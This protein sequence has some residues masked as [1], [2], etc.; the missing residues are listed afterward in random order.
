MEV[1]NDTEFE[2]LASLVKNK[3]GINLKSEK[4]Y[5][6][7]GRLQSVLNEKKIDSYGEYYQY[8]LHDPSGQGLKELVNRITTNHT[9]FMREPEHFEF[10]DRTVLPDIISSAGKSG[11]KDM[12]IWSAGCSSGEEPYCLAM[13]IQEHG[14][15]KP[16]EWD[17]KI[18][19]TDISPR[20]L[21]LAQ[22]G[23]YGPEQVSALPAL[24]KKKYFRELSAERY[25]VCPGI[26][27]EIIFRRF[28]LMNANFPFKKNFHVIFCRNVMIYFDAPTKHALVSK[29]EQVTEHGGFLF[30]GQSESL[31]KKMGS[32]RY[33]MP[34][35]YR[36][37]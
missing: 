19:A 35:V 31:G 36:R 18:L 21:E 37:D 5:L 13:I 8:L 1:L 15:F 17:S 4:K 3:Y 30:V 7:T 33:V 29:F 27:D 20:V 12:R 34:S 28:N 9:F 23:V 24:W 11:N 25:E 2:Q 22:E 6:I 26:K 32:Y 10:L 16:Q 14:G